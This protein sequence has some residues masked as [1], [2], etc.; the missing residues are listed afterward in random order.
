VSVVQPLRAYRFVVLGVAT[1]WHI[2]LSR[3]LTI[4]PDRQLQAAVILVVWCGV[5]FLA[6]ACLASYFGG[7]KI[8]YSTTVVLFASDVAGALAALYPGSSTDSVALVLQPIFA[9]VVVVPAALIL[10]R[11]TRGTKSTPRNKTIR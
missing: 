7:S 11:A 10:A 8:L 4:P 3:I 6:I 9:L 2:L 1:A 5:P